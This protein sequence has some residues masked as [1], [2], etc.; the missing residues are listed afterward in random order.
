MIPGELYK[1]L[2]DVELGK[3]YQGLSYDEYAHT[4]LNLTAL[5]SSYL[6]PL[7]KSPAHLQTSLQE[8]RVESE[9]FRQGKLVHK[10][11]EN[12]EKFMESYVV[13][14]EFTGLTKD[15]K[16]SKRSAEAKNLRCAWR[17]SIPDDKVILKTDDVDLI[18]GISKSVREHT[19]V[20]NL[21]KEGMSET[22][23]W[24]NDAEN[25]VTLASRPDFIAKEGFIVDIK[26]TRSAHPDDFTR[27]I[28]SPGGYHYVLQASLYARC[29]K[30]AGLQRSDSF[31]FIAI[32]KEPPYCLNVFP[33]DH[34]CL[35]VGDS[36][37]EKL[38]KL[39]GQCLKSGEWPGYSTKAVPVNIPTWVGWSEE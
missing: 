4:S 38:I 11:L 13:E 7:K 24:V 36:Y 23:L 16:D 10:F 12:P 9:A 30:L 26:T 6:K 25:E 20:R 3:L 39:Y 33:L 18:K 21:L 27:D 32:E 2:M 35:A 34:G 22:S 28:F 5:R 15:G 31:V 14:P 37:V 8:E 17:A 19:L 29:A 1:G